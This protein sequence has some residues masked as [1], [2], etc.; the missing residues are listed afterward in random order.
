[1]KHIENAI[2]CE[3]WELC[4][5]IQLHL[6][7]RE[8]AANILGHIV[9]H[10]PHHPRIGIYYIRATSV[11][12]K[13]ELWE[14]AAAYAN[15]AM[16]LE[17]EKIGV[18]ARS[19]LMFVMARI[20]DLWG[21]SLAKGAIEDGD[22]DGDGEERTAAAVEVE[23]EAEAE[24]ANSKHVAADMKKTLAAS[25]YQK[26]FY[27]RFGSG[28]EG[29]DGKEEEEEEEEKEQGQKNTLESTEAKISARKE[30]RRAQREAAIN[31]SKSVSILNTRQRFASFHGN[32]EDR[33]YSSCQEWL[34]DPKTWTVY[35][36]MAA[37]QEFFLIA[38]NFYQQ[39]I[40]ISAQREN[41]SMATGKL[42][43]AYAKSLKRIGDESMAKDYLRKV[44]VGLGVGV[45]EFCSE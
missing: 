19:D 2:S 21:R 23:A 33:E 25:A 5:R 17:V 32:D 12:M 41:R 3:N 11:L 20:V 4:V 28:E 18:F 15:A 39:A 42:Y 27:D 1:M 6:G 45:V 29:E 22:G 37:S 30:K 38:C 9:K 44:R 35:A 14:Q 10:F 24:G 26:I 16:D 8:K 43:L 34:D 13:L 40:D 7:N 31:N 36:E